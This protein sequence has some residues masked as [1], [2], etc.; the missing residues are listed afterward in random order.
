MLSYKS[1]AFTVF[2]LY[3]V[4]ICMC[5]QYTHI[6]KRRDLK[7]KKSKNGRKRLLSGD[8]VSSRIRPASPLLSSL[9]SIPLS[10]PPSIYLLSPVDPRQKKKKK[11]KRKKKKLGG[12]CCRANLALKCLPRLPRLTRNTV[13]PHQISLFAPGASWAPQLC[14]PPLYLWC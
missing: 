13:K 2:S 14:P 9:H 5:M 1:S 3:T 7:T 12:R 11:K 8:G 4:E 6:K 10:L